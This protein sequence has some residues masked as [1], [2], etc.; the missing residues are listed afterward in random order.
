MKNKSNLYLGIFL[1]SLGILFLLKNFHVVDVSMEK[2]IR[3]WPFLL[4]FWGL[5]FIPM[6]QTWRNAVNI[7]LLVLFYLLLFFG[8]QVRWH[9]FSSIWSDESPVRINRTG[10]HIGTGGDEENTAGTNNAQR[11]MYFSAEMNP[12]IKKAVMSLELAAMEL[13]VNSPTDK[14]YELTVED[15]PFEMQALYRLDNGT[16]RIEIKPVEKEANNVKHLAS[17]ELHLNADIPWELEINSGASRLDL[18]LSPYI[19]E[20]L[21]IQTGAAQLQIKLGAKAPKTY[22]EINAGASDVTLKVPEEAAVEL[23]M[24]NLFSANSLNGF[25]QVEKNLYRSNNFD[26]SKPLIHITV[27]SAISKWRIERY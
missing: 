5:K 20:K 6:S 22:V 12:Q 27:N 15:L 23:E 13:H 14:L 17:G 9:S 4:I 18:D 21:K 1:L 7:A 8:P 16:A 26:K 25:T 3:L 11:D 24:N 19:I 2:L 10:I